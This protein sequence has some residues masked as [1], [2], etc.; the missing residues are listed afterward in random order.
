MVQESFEGKPAKKGFILL[1]SRVLGW[2]VAS[3]AAICR[4]GRAESVLRYQR[5]LINQII[6]ATPNAV[7]VIDKDMKVLLANATFYKRFHLEKNRVENKPICELIKVEGLKRAL[8]TIIKDDKS[9]L[10]FEFR[11]EVKAVPRIFVARTVK[12]QNN[13]HLVLISDVTEERESQER[14]YLTD[15]LASVGEMAAG[16][17]HELNNPLTSIIGLSSLLTRQEMPAETREDLLAIN[18][19]AQ[20]CAT[21][22]KGLLA[23]AR[24]HAPKREPLQLTRVV[25]DVLKL[26]AYELHSQNINV[27]ASLPDDLP[28]VMADYFQL[29]QAF[30]NIVLNAEAA[31]TEANGH[32]TL[33]VSGERVNGNIH[34]AFSDDGPGITRE[35]MGLIFNPFFTTKE[36]GEG[37][38]L[39]LSICYGIVASHGGKIYAKSNNEKGATFVVEIPI[40]GS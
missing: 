36:V 17:A 2:L 13:R 25:E 18:A 19:E 5:C 7:L 38:G 1:L 14:L 31:M 35:N 9:S 30:L 11:Y 24:K 16:V 15:R 8:A 22:V 39:G 33:R 37:S 23:F 32:G 27:E 6:A 20:R 28:E 34:I 4:W 3:G 12:M 29:Q 10:S 40:I 26:R 21:I